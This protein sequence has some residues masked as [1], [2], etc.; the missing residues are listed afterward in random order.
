MPTRK[1]NAPRRVRSARISENR[2]DFFSE[3]NRF[4]LCTSVRDG[5]PSRTVR[6]EQKSTRRDHS[7]EHGQVNTKVKAYPAST[8]TQLVHAGADCDT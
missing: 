5:N 4:F 8:S 2:I 1:V 7:N 6:T 3:P